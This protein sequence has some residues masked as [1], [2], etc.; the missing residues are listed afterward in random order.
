MKIYPVQQGSPEWSALRCGI[1]TASRFDVLM[2]AEARKGKLTQGVKTYLLAKLEEWITGALSD[3]GLGGFVERG[4]MLE[5]EAIANYA[6]DREVTVVP[7][8][9]VTLDDGSAG[10]SP[11]GLVGTDG[12]VE[13]KCYKLQHHL[14]A[15]IWSDNA[16]YAQVQ[17]NLLIT[18]RQW[19][20]RIYYNPILP[21][22]VVR[23]ERHERYITELAVSVEM[24]NGHLAEAKAKLLALGA[25]P[26]KG[27]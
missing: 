26:R 6:F 7:C 13:A 23:I 5:P 16:H 21:P 10:C 19:C 18:E 4:T 12:M 3:D 11:D 22:V 25:K 2:T 1:P 17:G 8:G 14:D 24:F 15:L 9:F 20:D 27:I